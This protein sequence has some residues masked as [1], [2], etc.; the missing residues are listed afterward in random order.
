MEAEG[1]ALDDRLAVDFLA[2]GFAARAFGDFLAA[3]FLP[4]GAF[5]VDFA[6]VFLA[7][8]FVAISSGSFLFSAHITPVNLSPEG[9]D[10]RGETSKNKFRSAPLM[11]GEQAATQLV[12]E[13]SCCISI[14]HS[15]A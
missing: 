8:F 1:A 7:A 12:R 15:L 11:S 2:A 13:P 4:A 5:L 14:G 9:A 10:E 6:A 3:G